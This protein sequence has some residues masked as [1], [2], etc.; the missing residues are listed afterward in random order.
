MRV[1]CVRLPQLNAF[2][3]AKEQVV[4]RPAMV[5]LPWFSSPRSRTWQTSLVINRRDQFAITPVTFRHTGGAQP[6]FII[7]DSE[8][9][10]REAARRIIEPSASLAHTVTRTPRESPIPAPA[11]NPLVC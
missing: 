2:A 3:A 5:S 9:L 4:Q 11:A 7:D 1:N 8:S 10:C 6:D